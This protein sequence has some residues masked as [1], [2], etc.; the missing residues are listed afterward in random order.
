MTDNL[1]ITEVEASQNDKVTPINE[2]FNQL[3]NA[4]QSTLSV[5]VEDGTP[6]V[7]DDI[8]FNNNFHFLIADGAAAPSATFIVAIPTN[9]RVFAVT[10]NTSVIA[11][12]DNSTTTIDIDVGQTVLLITDGQTFF[13]GSVS[14]SSD[15]DTDTDTPTPMVTQLIMALGDSNM[16]GF[17][18]DGGLYQ[19]S[20]D[21]IDATIT[22]L[23][24]IPYDTS[25]VPQ[26]AILLDD[27]MDF[28]P[29]AFSGEITVSPASWVGRELIVLDSN[30]QLAVIPAAVP[31]TGLDNSD[32]NPP[33]GAH[34]LVARNGILEGISQ[35]TTASLTDML[36][37]GTGRVAET[38]LTPLESSTNL[39][40]L[41]DTLR[42]DASAPN[43][44]G[45]IMS[46]PLIH[47]YNWNQN[48]TDQQE[49]D[50]DVNQRQLPLDNDNLIYVS[51][52]LRYLDLADWLTTGAEEVIEP[53]TDNH[54]ETEA[55][56]ELGRVTSRQRNLV[57]GLTANIP[58][59]PLN[60]ADA[61]NGY[62]SFEIP[63]SGAH[64]FQ[65]QYR[66][67][68]TTDTFVQVDRELYWRGQEPGET[69]FANIPTTSSADQEVQ[70]RSVSRAGFSAWS[71]SVTITGVQRSQGWRVIVNASNGD[72]FVNCNQLGFR[73]FTNGP[74]IVFEG[75]AIQG[76][77]FDPSFAGFAAFDGR[78][79][80]TLWVSSN[81]AAASGD[82]WIGVFFNEPI[83]VGE[84]LWASRNDG[85]SQASDQAPMDF[86]LERS[87][88][89]DTLADINAG[90]AT[91]S[92][93]LNITGETGWPDTGEVRT[94]T[95]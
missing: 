26:T 70:V 58:D 95:V 23:Y 52:P 6:A 59:I 29:S 91:W 44:R 48:S 83:Y 40:N 87:G 94:F 34:Y 55:Y 65:I 19:A 1:N 82:A 20:P 38:S 8:Q 25:S 81:N 50:V 42:S 76:S 17:R 79:S 88:I 18:A 39:L 12:L 73:G 78:R 16:T 35:F 24:Q 93:V 31:S 4:T 77:Q 5:L 75:Q 54:Y 80:D 2:G 66:D 47:S 37:I 14:I 61:T 63:A 62:V 90:T 28:P 11:T 71:P 72:L 9:Q 84:F 64:R 74:D 46:P 86:D 22:G 69:Y 41:F 60:V 92:A 10:N 21:A 36:W 30:N 57:D 53:N 13:V 67:S 89:S 33:S 15:T 32:W 3:D 56:R 68:G 85:A 45:I 27:P 49:I 7:I 51:G 43:A